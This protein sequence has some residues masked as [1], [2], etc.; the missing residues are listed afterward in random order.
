MNTIKYIY[1]DQINKK[2]KWL[3]K[4][5]KVISRYKMMEYILLHFSL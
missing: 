4:N 2:N 5:I 3:C 1:M